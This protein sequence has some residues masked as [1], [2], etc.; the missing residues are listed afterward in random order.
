MSENS[1]IARSLAVT[2]S[3]GLGD[4]SIAAVGPEA[5]CLLYS[6]VLTLPSQGFSQE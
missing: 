1:S 6:H 4:D 5:A 3:R 2:D